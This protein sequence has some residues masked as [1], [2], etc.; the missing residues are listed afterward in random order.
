ML[1]TGNVS[2]KRLVNLE[3]NIKKLVFVSVLFKKRYFCFQ[4]KNINH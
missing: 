1:L 3:I 2:I 4:I